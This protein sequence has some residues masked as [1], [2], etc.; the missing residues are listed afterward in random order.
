[1]EF[2]QKSDQ[3]EN[4]LDQMFHPASRSECGSISF[5]SGKPAQF[6]LHFV[7]W[8]SNKSLQFQCWVLYTTSAHGWLFVNSWKSRK[9]IYRGRSRCLRLFPQGSLFTGAA[10]GSLWELQHGRG[11]RVP[12]GDSWQSQALAASLTHL[13]WV[14]MG[15][16]ELY[17]IK[18]DL[19]SA[20]RFVGLFI[21]F[22][23][24][25]HLFHCPLLLVDVI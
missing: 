2:F 12:D 17:T 25:L 13:L 24:P 5:G 4:N 3:V 23:F 6:P 20:W 18:T 11:A 8:A 16:L 19:W 7:L 10:S 15:V 21:Y 14:L 9:V 22:N 1:M